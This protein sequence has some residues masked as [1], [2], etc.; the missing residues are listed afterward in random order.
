M[1]INAKLQIE[2]R[3]QN[4]AEEEFH[5]GGEVPH[6][7]VVQSKNKKKKKEKR[8]RRRRRKIRGG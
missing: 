3:G 2:K 4:R 1:L 7:S 5:S 6:W 8:K